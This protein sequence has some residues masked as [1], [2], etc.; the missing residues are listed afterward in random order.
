MLNNL[1]FYF[2]FIIS[3]RF[4]FLITNKDLKEF[5]ISAHV[6]SNGNKCIKQIATEASSRFNMLKHLRTGC[7]INRNSAN[8]SRFV[9]GEC[10]AGKPIY[11]ALQRV[12]L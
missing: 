7:R 12:N 4:S 8:M 10:S 1:L 11:F 6:A 3:V 5:T 9:R 2:T